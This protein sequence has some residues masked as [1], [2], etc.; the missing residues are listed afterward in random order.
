MRQLRVAMLVP[1]FACA[2]S[3]GNA[4]GAVIS[5]SGDECGTPP[6]LGLTFTLPT[7]LENCSSSPDPIQG[8]AGSVS[9]EDDGPGTVYG[10]DILSIDFLVTTTN[11][12]FFQSLRVGDGSALTTI[13]LIPGGF[14]LFNEFGPGICPD[15]PSTCPVDVLITL[16]DLAPE[17]LGTSITVTAVNTTQVPEPAAVAFVA[18]GLAA[19]VAR[20]R[21]SRWPGGRQPRL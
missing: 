21:R 10:D 17:D 5:V 6:L 9:P 1:V 4:R 15:G 14:R 18:T 7:A 11:P 2:M 16:A 8:I 3:V 19:V 12:L 20:R 13:E